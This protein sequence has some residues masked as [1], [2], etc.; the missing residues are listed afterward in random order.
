M[1]LLLIKLLNIVCSDYIEVV[2]R[3][4]DQMKVVDDHIL[5]RLRILHAHVH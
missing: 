2:Q 3:K 1:S 4:G 5:V